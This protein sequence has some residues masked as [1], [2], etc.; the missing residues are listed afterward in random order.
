MSQTPGLKGVLAGLELA[1]LVPLGPVPGAQDARTPLFLF[2]KGACSY[3]PEPRKGEM[4]RGSCGSDR[5][6]HF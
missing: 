3:A 4:T 2:G 1:P 6:C 5:T